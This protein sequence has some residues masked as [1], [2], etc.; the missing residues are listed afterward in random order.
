[1]HPRRSSLFLVAALA[2]LL[3]FA[4]ASGGN[5]R[6]AGVA[7]PEVRAGINGTVFFGSGNTAPA[8]VDVFVTNNA[9]VPI[10]L[11]RVQVDSPGMATYTLIR[12]SRDF[13][14]TIGPGATERV[15]VFSTAVTEVRNPSEP[16]T[17]RVISD[18]E[19]GKDRWR[20]ITMA[21]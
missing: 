11:R 4:C 8:N 18:F 20:E 3:A 13:R 14:Q 10:V 12:S 7:A 2:A 15:T 5:S 1:M 6:P 9:N 21:R 16:L 17:I 19:L